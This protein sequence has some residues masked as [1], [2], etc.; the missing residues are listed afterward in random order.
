MNH[1][2]YIRVHLPTAAENVV[3]ETCKRIKKLTNKNSEAGFPDADLS[4][5]SI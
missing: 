4:G 5:G 3:V 2:D 1:P